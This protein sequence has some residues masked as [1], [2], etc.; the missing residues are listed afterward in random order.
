MAKSP[1]P[2]KVQCSRKS[3]RRTTRDPKAAHWVYVS[4]ADD[5]VPHWVGWWCP[6]CIEELKRFMEAQGVEPIIERLQ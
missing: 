6:Q 5:P 3:C 1:I 2:D 4:E